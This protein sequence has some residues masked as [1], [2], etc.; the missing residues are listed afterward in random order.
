M[1]NILVDFNKPYCFNHYH[2][3]ATTIFTCFKIKM[4]TYCKAMPFTNLKTIT[5]DQP[6]F[7]HRHNARIIRK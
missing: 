1:I 6:N 2:T 5:T 4:S 7:S 3:A